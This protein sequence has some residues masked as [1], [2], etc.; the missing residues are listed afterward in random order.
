MPTAGSPV[1]IT[2]PPPPLVHTE[3]SASTA[4]WG[5]LLKWDWSH[6]LSANLLTPSSC[7]RPKPRSPRWTEGHVLCLSL[8]LLLSRPLP[9]SAA[10]CPF[11]AS[12]TSPSRGLALSAPSPVSLPPDSCWACSFISF[13]A[14]LSPN[15]FQHC[16]PWKLF[17]M[18]ASLLPTRAVL[19]SP[20]LSLPSLPVGTFWCTE[21]LVMY[22]C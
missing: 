16:F 13:K 21:W 8:S 6:H 7:S 2:V 12:G 10:G 14:W 4:A 15:L 11:N 17:R 1:P 20:S 22:F 19:Q 3:V 5:V 9:G 18:A